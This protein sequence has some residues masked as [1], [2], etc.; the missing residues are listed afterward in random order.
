MVNALRYVHY[1]K[2]WKNLKMITVP[3]EIERLYGELKPRLDLYSSDL[4]KELYTIDLPR[5]S[6]KE[7]IS[8]M[9]SYLNNIYCV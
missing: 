4:A 9:N 1:N 5:T 6:Y 7:N 2:T 8:L 3:W